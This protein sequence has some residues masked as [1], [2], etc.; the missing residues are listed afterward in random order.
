MK[1][2][3]EQDILF[4]MLSGDPAAEYPIG[5]RVEKRQGEEDDRTPLGSQ[6]TVRGNLHCPSSIKDTIVMDAY[7]VQFDGSPALTFIVDYKL[8]RID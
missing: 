6:G 5:T 4:H 3:T 2:N 7:L 1:F 8:K